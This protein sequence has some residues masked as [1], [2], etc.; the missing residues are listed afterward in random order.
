MIVRLDFETASEAKLGKKDAVGAWRYAEHPTTHILCLQYRIDNGEITLWL[1]DAPFPQDLIDAVKQGATF[2]AFN[3]GFEKAIW[4]FLVT[5]KLGVPYPA[6]WVCTMAA[7]A[8]RGLPQGLDDLG[9]VLN[10]PVQKDKRGKYLI[11]R[12]CKRHKPSKKWPTGW[13]RDPEL[14][15]ELY[16]YCA[17]DV[18][19][20][21]IAAQ[22][23]GPIPPAEQA[24]W[25]LDQKIN[26]RGILVDQESLFAAKK[27]AESVTE[28]LFA[29]VR[30]I[31]SHQIET[32]NQV[33]ALGAWC[34]EQGV[35]IPNMQ[36]DTV[37]EW[38]LK[39]TLPQY[40]KRALQI[41]QQTSKS[42]VKKLE[43]IERYLMGDGRIR[44]TLAYYG[45]T[46]GRWAGRGPQVHNFPR[47]EDLD[48]V[49]LELL[50]D[51][52]KL[53]DLAPFG[54]PM[55]SLSN[56]LRGMFISGPGNDLQ[57]SD[58]KAIEGVG[59]AYVAGEEWKLEAFRRG[60]DIYCTT[61]HQIF[62]HP[63][64]KK[65][66]PKE[67]QIGK[68]CELAFGYQGAVGAWRNFDKT[69]NYTDDEVQ[70]FKRAWRKKH[71][72]TVRIWRELEMAAGRAIRTGEPQYCSCVI[73]DT[74][75]DDAGDWLSIVLP[76]GRRLW[77]Y[78]PR[79]ELVDGPYGPKYELTCHKRNNKRGGIWGEIHLYGGLILENIVQAISRDIMVEGMFA[80]EAANYPLI[81]TV[82]DELVSE[83]FAAHGSTEEFDRLI[84]KPLPWLPDFPLSASGFRANR[85]RK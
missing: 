47:G 38:A 85:Y 36:A 42:S 52:I 25:E 16:E 67:R 23:L 58:Y 20:E 76:N 21:E 32:T 24:I 60:E 30:D 35:P 71:P 80:V 51:A 78:N 9:T 82:H 77:Y 13:V 28:E 18:E 33:A 64:S 7:A 3:A 84:T 53:G 26:E 15:Q 73:F 29:E 74:V 55:Q 1:P 63:V 8:Y 79:A 57:V 11:Q 34:R 43:A 12:L 27:I 50:H 66:N 44:G 19:T 56:A 14:L 62:G 5:G 46:T 22:V 59:T 72:A 31:T 49:D 61:A 54:D 48:G 17:V 6:E 81:L 68:I 65:D 69:D 4:W 45:A 2:T 75:S 10:L 41:R 40:V 83:P 39:S 37:E 70:E